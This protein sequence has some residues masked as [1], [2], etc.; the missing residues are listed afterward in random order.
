[1]RQQFP[2]KLFVPDTFFVS[3]GC[4]GGKGIMAKNRYVSSFGKLVLYV[5][6]FRVNSS[7][8]FF[9]FFFFLGA[10]EG[11]RPKRGLPGTFPAN[12]GYSQTE[13]K[14]MPP[15]ARPLIGRSSTGPVFWLTYAGYTLPRLPWLACTLFWPSFGYD[16]F[17]FAGILTRTAHRYQI[18]HHQT[19]TR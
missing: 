3:W 2:G 7:F 14:I 11:Q 4:G 17:R 9:F 16:L 10:G 5:Q 8:L 1:M 19:P 12:T 13:L 6:Q 18:T 15:K